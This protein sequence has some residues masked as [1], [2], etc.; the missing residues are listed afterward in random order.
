MFVW[1]SFGFVV[2]RSISCFFLGGCN[3]LLY[4]GV[5]HLLSFVGLDLQNDCLNLVLSWDVLLSPSM[6]IKSF[7]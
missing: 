1:L 7:G 5:F 2:K 3:F 4:V 6:V